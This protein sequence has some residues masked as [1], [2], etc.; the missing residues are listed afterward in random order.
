MA[1]K[2]RSSATRGIFLSFTLLAV[3]LMAIV[4]LIVYARWQTHSPERVKLAATMMEMQRRAVEAKNAVLKARESLPADSPLA[5]PWD[6]AKAVMAGNSVEIQILNTLASALLDNPDDLPQRMRDDLRSQLAPFRAS[7]QLTPFMQSVDPETNTPEQVMANL[8]DYLCTSTDLA[9]IENGLACGLCA[10]IPVYGGPAPQMDRK[11]LC[12]SARAVAE[13]QTGNL[14]KAVDTCL[15]AYRLAELTTQSRVLNGIVEKSATDMTTDR[16][17]WRIADISPLSAPDQERLLAEIDKRRSTTGLAESYRFEAAHMESGE[18]WGRRSDNPIDLFFRGRYGRGSMQA[19]E[20]FVPILDQP[21]YK[22]KN[23]LDE[24]RRAFDGRGGGNHPFVWTAVM[25]YT[26]HAED[27]NRA[28]AAHVGFA[29]KAWKR[30]HGAYP[31]SL[32]ALDPKPLD[33]E[34]LDPN[35]GKPAQ[36]ETTPE[37]GFRISV[38]IDPASQ[39]EHRSRGTPARNAQAKTIAL[40][41]EAHN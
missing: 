33:T 41:W 31:P 17:V 16:A 13:A 7:K 5:P 25:A 11:S 2:R 8:R 38:P 39:Q 3:V 37:G 27:A 4:A 19:A 30:E 20:R 34:L 35:T 12:L 26:G 9:Q 23:Q 28:E 22:T 10:D 21:P 29:L 40:L 36:Y 1:R 14:A 6:C 24:I 18:M 15:C 32:D